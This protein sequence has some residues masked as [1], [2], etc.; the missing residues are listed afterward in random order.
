MSRKT[1]FMVPAELI[2]RLNSEMANQWMKFLPDWRRNYLALDEDYEVRSSLLGT[3]RT[4][5]FTQSDNL[6]FLL[7]ANAYGIDTD[8]HQLNLIIT[9]TAIESSSTPCSDR[10]STGFFYFWYALG[11][12]KVIR[13]QTNTCKMQMLFVFLTGSIGQIS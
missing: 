8:T 10:L 11:S 4:P 1:F 2:N 3:Q 7:E 13:V 6:H 12:P 9:T 5:N